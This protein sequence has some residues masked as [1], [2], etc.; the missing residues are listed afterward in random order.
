MVEE[1]IK[2]DQDLFI[3][4]VQL[5]G[6]KGSQHLLVSMDGDNGIQIDKCASISRQLGHQLE[7]M[8]LIG[9][10]YNLE[11]SSA[12]L[13]EPLKLLRQFKKNEGRTL[14][15]KLV[16]GDKITGVLKSSAEGGIVL[17]DEGEEKEVN[18]KDIDKS[19]VAVSFK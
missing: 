15:V 9:G 7:E 8:D 11:V 4:D 18:F 3:V 2:D 14:K 10:K 16:S 17:E 12:G 5:K 1:I 19:T 13:S 6:H